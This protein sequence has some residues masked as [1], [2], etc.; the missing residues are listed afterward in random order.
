MFLSFESQEER[1]EYGGS[2]FLE[3]QF[4]R[5]PVGTPVKEIVD[6]DN[7]KDWKD[8]SLY[9]SDET[10]FVKIYGSFFTGG[11]Y[12]N[13]QTGA[14]DLCGINYYSPKQTEKMISQLLKEKPTDY[15]RLICWLKEA[16]SY[17]GF[18]VLGI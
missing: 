1:R 4:C 13:L 6:I 3:L 9:V 7:I 8:D 15:K 11:V 17:N 2:D 16:L 14:V 12:N 18:Y 5:L 10:D